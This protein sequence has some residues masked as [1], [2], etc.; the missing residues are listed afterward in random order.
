M[1]GGVVSASIVISK[2][3][4]LRLVQSSKATQV[5][6][7]VPGENRLPEGGSQMTLTVAEWLSV[8]GGAGYSTGIGLVVQDLEKK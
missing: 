4:V 7:V 3:H 5:T 2:V 8:A 1:V 6:S